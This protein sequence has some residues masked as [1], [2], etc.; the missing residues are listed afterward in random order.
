MLADLE[1]FRRNP[2]VKF[3]YHDANAP[4]AEEPTR[5]IDKVVSNTPERRSSGAAGRRPGTRATAARKK[6][7]APAAKRAGRLV[8]PIIAGMA[9]AFAVGAAI[10]ILLFSAPPAPRCSAMWRM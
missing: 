3:E 2:N 4:L 1:E 10:L 9:A 7:H 5:Y 6:A 8:L